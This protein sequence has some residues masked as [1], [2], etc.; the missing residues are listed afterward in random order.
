MDYLLLFV[1][2]VVIGSFLNVVI[3]RIPMGE[4]IVAPPSH[5]PKCNTLLK[6]WDLVPILSWLFLRAKCRYCD[7]TVSCRYPL[8]EL[9]TGLLFVFT[10]VQ[11]GIHNV[12]IVYL[13]LTSLL[14]AD[15]FIDLDHFILPD[16][17]HIF[18]ALV[19][20]LLNLLFSFIPWKDALLGL[21]VGMAPLLL[22]VLLTGGN[23]MGLGD[24]KLMAML[25]LFLGWKLT[26]LTLLLSFILGGFFGV[27]LLMTKIKT[28]KDPI[29]F[30]PWI[31]MAAFIAMHWGEEIIKLY[32]GTI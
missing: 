7:T 2:G 3:Y 18:G 23:G 29:P 15:T 5:C 22:L 11:V 17:L 31:A 19:F 14:I 28:R 1:L 9:F 13:V 10:Y 32:L 30:G 4:S 16:G 27:V 21:I 6:P 25:G 12:L 20:I 8:V 26:L 24:V